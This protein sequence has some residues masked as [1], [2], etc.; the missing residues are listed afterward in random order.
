MIANREALQ[1]ASSASTAYDEVPYESGAFSFAHPGR[2]SGIARLRGL[3]AAAPATCSY[4][5]IGCALGQN[6]LPLAIQLPSARFVGVDLS[7]CQIARAQEAAG[8][9][10][11]SNARFFHADAA[12]AVAEIVGPFDYVVCHGVLSWVPPET[13]AGI[14]SRIRARLA[15]NGVAMVSFNAWPG[16]HTLLAVRQLALLASAGQASLIARVHTAK[17]FFARVL[18]GDAEAL[19]EPLRKALRA[20]IDADDSYLAHEHFSVVNEP[21]RSD[22]FL[23]LCERH[24]L[25][26]LANA[27]LEGEGARRSLA[28]LAGPATVP[29]SVAERETMLDIMA[30][31]AF[32]TLLLCRTDARVNEGDVLENLLGMSV[33]VEPGARCVET[34]DPLPALRVVCGERET[35]LLLPAAVTVA[36]RVF[37]SAPAYVPVRQLIDGLTAQDRQIALRTVFALALS[38]AC[39]IVSDALPISASIDSPSRLWPWA[40][41]CLAVSSPWFCGVR[42][43]S[44]RIDGPTRAL[45]GLIDGQRS[46]DELRHCW[47]E[48]AVALQEAAADR[49]GGLAERFDELLSLIHATGAL[50]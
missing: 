28:R 33:A 25:R 31:T 2:M 42:H 1:R 21:I 18:A 50:Q 34:S 13:Q 35:R 48:R 43:Q 24:G 5:E 32:R 26:F 44:H 49:P 23:V 7:S 12:E 17:A 30:G 14:L 20:F 36:R 3:P 46:I 22:A 41:H 10:R 45:L 9:L 4:L 37:A 39:D 27:T 15:P 11:V 19:E 8:A 6:L 16:A 40:A 29:C 47:I 38:G